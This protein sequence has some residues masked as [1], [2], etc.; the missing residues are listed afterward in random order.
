MKVFL[1]DHNNNNHFHNIYD[2]L[3]HKYFIMYKNK[4]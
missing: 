1:K 3:S 4:I 2:I